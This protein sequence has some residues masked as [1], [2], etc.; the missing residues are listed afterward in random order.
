MKLYNPQVTRDGLS[1]AMLEISGRT[2]CIKELGKG[3]PW[4]NADDNDDLVETI[5]AHLRERESAKAR[6]PDDVCVALDECRADLNYLFGR[7]A[8]DGS[9]CRAAEDS[10]RLKLNKVAAFHA[11]LSAAPKPKSSL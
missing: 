10:M 11:S 4:G 5:A 6:V 1:L 8:A 7:V 3:D 2:F 9:F